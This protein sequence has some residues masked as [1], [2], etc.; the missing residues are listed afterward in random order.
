MEMLDYEFMKNALD[1]SP[2]VFVPDRSLPVVRFA[3]T[4]F[5]DTGIIEIIDAFEVS[6]DMFDPNNWKEI[7]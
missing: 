4:N 5:L 1:G 7:K 2:V 6:G 3:S